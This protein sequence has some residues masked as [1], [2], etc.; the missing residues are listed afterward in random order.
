MLS[1]VEVR[2]PQGD[3]LIL[4][5]EDVYEGLLIEKID[6][7][8][9]VAAVLAS[10]N[11][12]N[13]D[14]AQYQSSYRDTRNI[15]LRVN[16]EPDPATQ[17]V[18]GLRSVLYRYFM[19]KSEVFLRFFDDEGLTVNI[20]ARVEKCEAALFT[21]KPAAD[22]SVICYDP[23]FVDVDTELF[24]F[25][26]TASTTDDAGRLTVPY[27]GTVDTGFEFKLLVDRSISGFTLYHRPPNNVTRTMDFAASLISGD[28]LTISTVAGNKGATLLRSGVTSSVLYG[29]S[30]QYTWDN[31]IPG[32]NYMRAYV[33]G[34]EI[35]F[36]LRYMNRYGG[37]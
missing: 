20:A 10:S 11:F 8:D 26:T 31:L 1:K 28:V 16:L 36:E 32:T 12:A 37:L 14:G 23:D 18:R 4:P 27:T 30:P 2:S 5:L 15:V 29:V 3:L 17:T 21:D 13:L 19:P 9:P 24:E 33:T 22:I 34:A 6:G 35:P 25:H 7:L